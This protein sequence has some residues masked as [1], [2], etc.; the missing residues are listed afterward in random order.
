[1][2]IVLSLE[3]DYTYITYIHHRLGGR[4]CLRLLGGV[5]LAAVDYSLQQKQ[6]CFVVR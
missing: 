4:S 6:T 1:M 3:L 2:G 5:F